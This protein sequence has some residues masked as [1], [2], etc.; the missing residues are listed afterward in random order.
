MT[1][2]PPT[3]PPR[4]GTE[5]EECVPLKKRILNSNLRPAGAGREFCHSS[6][7][8]SLAAFVKTGHAHSGAFDTSAAV[9]EVFWLGKLQCLPNRAK[10]LPRLG[11]ANGKDAQ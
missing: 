11:K 9:R 7:A 4:Q 5:N 8:L 3:P 10:D 1:I 2:V 6:F